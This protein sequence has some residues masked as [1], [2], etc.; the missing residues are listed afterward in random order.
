M[1]VQYSP[2]ASSHPIILSDITWNTAQV[3][4]SLNNMPCAL[5]QPF[6]AIY[7]FSIQTQRFL[8]L[9]TMESHHSLGIPSIVDD[10]FFVLSNFQKAQQLVYQNLIHYLAMMIYL[11]T[12]D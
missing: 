4:F 2:F 7:A 11:D 5:Q 8:S 3:L 12:L 9:S 1:H 6:L 10:V